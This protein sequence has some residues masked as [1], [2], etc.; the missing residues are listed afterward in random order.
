MSGE[1]VL[2]AYIYTQAHARM[3]IY[4]LH[5]LQPTTDNNQGWKV[6]AWSGKTWQV[7]CFGKIKKLRLDLNE[8]REGFFGEEGEGHSM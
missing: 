4:T 2:S 3:S 7:Y 6:A 8:S 1:T 5:N